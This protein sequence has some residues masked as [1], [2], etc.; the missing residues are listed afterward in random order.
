VTTKKGVDDK[1]ETP[2][3]VPVSEGSVKSEE[4]RVV[5][6]QGKLAQPQAR[7]K[8]TK[9]AEKSEHHCGDCKWYDKS[10]ER[11]FH[12]NGIRRGL[13]ETRAICKAPAGHS[14]ASKHLVKHESNRSCFVM[15][16]HSTSLK[17]RKTARAVELSFSA[18]A[19]SH[20]PAVQ[21]QRSRRFERILQGLLPNSHD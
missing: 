6:Q 16:A 10:T 19:R 13:V 5:E 15:V 17:E 1:I 4:T 12:R 2:S 21:R 8:E 18:R 14:K 9:T 20:I 3:S 11:Q 7:K